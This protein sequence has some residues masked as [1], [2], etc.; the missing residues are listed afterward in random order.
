MSLHWGPM[1]LRPPTSKERQM[2]VDL[3]KPR[4]VDERTIREIF[5]HYLAA[6]DRKHMTLKQ[7]LEGR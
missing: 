4:S 7:Y 3:F 1:T 2:I 5:D 6:A